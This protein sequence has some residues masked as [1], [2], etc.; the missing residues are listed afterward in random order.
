MQSYEDK[1]AYNRVYNQQWRH[2][3]KHSTDINDLRQ[4]KLMLKA[5]KQRARRKGLA[6]N[7]TPADILIPKRCPALG[8]VLS[9]RR[10]GRHGGQKSSPSLDRIIPRK[11]Y[12]RGNVIVVSHLAN[13]IKNVGT[14]EQIIR[15]GRFFKRL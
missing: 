14:P 4:R 8:I 12:V 1:L 9:Y 13:M 7:L 15:V 11:G 5:A 3:L 10:T 2:A 6:F